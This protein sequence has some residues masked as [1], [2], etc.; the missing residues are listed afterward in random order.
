MTAAPPGPNLFSSLADEHVSLART[1]ETFA[2]S[3]IGQA[4]ILA[5]IIYFTSFVIVGPHD[6]LPI[7]DLRNSIVFYGT[8]GGGGARDPLPASVGD[9]PSARPEAPIVPATVMLPKAIPKLPVP[10][11]VMA[12]AVKISLSGQIGDPKSPFT[13]WLSNGQGGPGGIGNNGC[14]DGIG[15]GDGPRVGSG[16]RGVYIPG[17]GGVSIPVATYSPEPTFSDE[18]RKQKWQGIVTLMLIVGT[19][20]RPY[21]I[22]VRQSA[23][24]GLDEQAVE[25]VKNWRFR[26]ATLGGQPVDA[27]IEVEVNFHLY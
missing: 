8:S 17:K 23:G 6:R 11:S 16:P 13:Q 21:N 24:M 4:A 9:I 15:D 1:R 20:G 7:P 25:T 14:C 3:F 2:A 22:H 18:A 12:P 10:E 5:V 19:D 26:P 27:R